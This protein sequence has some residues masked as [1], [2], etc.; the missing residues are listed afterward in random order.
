MRRSAFNR[1]RWQVERERCQ[2]PADVRPHAG[3]FAARPVGAVIPDVI[4]NLGI[5]DPGWLRALETDW[6]ALVGGQVAKHARPG[7]YQDGVLVVFVDSA[8]WLNELKRYSSGD[9]LA[10]LRGRFGEEKIRK[11]SIQPDPDTAAPGR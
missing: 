8:V 3:G 11:L 5:E 7:R 9:L 10:R 6:V 1:G 4:R 2:I